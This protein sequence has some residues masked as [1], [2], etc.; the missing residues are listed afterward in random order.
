MAARVAAGLI[1]VARVAIAAAGSFV[2]LVALSACPR[3]MI[4]VTM[5]VAVSASWTGNRIVAVGVVE[6]TPWGALVATRTGEAVVAV[7]GRGAC[8]HVHVTVPVPAAIQ[9]ARRRLV[10]VG[11]PTVPGRALAAV[12]AIEAGIA[13][14]TD[15]GLIVALPVTV[16]VAVPRAT[17]ARI[18]IGVVPAAALVASGTGEAIFAFAAPSARVAVTMV[19]AT[20]TV[21]RVTIAVRVGVILRRAR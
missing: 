5:T 2:P 3:V 12:R 20:D 15:P 8:T 18:A 6:V 16:A 1:A 14:G 13:G 9:W 11:I 10:T 17:L 7:A 19:T 21:A 4:A